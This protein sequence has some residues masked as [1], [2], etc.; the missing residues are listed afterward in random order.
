VQNADVKVQFE[1]ALAAQEPESAL[2]DLP[3]TLKDGAM[4]QTDMLALFTEFPIRH[5]DDKD[6]RLYDAIMDTMDFVS[7][8]CH[9]S[10]RLFDSADD[11]QA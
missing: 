6:E 8:W 5:R 3:R 11:K 7:G 1:T 2:H 4:S 10:F 9:K